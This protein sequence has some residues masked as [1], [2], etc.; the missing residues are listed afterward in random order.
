MTFL[1]CTVVEARPK[2]SSV[3]DKYTVKA[4]I[5]PIILSSLSG[6]PFSGKFPQ[7]DEIMLGIVLL[8]GEG[9]RNYVTLG[10]SHISG[11]KGK[12]T[13]NFAESRPFSYSPD[14]P[15]EIVISGAKFF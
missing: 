13:S 9:V 6:I 5:A 10:W 11:F 12:I 15:K 4:N 1:F 7:K 14:A 3:I 2:D 8:K